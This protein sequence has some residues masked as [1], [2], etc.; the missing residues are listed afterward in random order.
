M[1]L[2]RFSETCSSSRVRNRPFTRTKSDGGE[3]IILLDSIGHVVSSGTR[4]SSSSGM[5]VGTRCVRD[6]IHLFLSENSG[7]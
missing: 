3:E 6:W 1:R 4:N 7:R 5:G 2:D